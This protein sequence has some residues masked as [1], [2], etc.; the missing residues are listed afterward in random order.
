MPKCTEYA[1]V[2]IYKCIIAN[3]GKKYHTKE[4]KEIKKGHKSYLQILWIL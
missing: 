1:S 3:I 4:K 2:Y